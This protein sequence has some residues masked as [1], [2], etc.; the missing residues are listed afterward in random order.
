[1]IKRE[2]KELFHNKWMMVILI[3]VI[4]I[5]TIYT[6]LFLGSMWDP[7]GNLDKLPVAV[8]NEDRSVSYEGKTLSVGKDLQE[9][10]ETDDS[11]D[12][13]IV[14]KKQAK[15]GLK[16]G[17]YYMAIT[18]PEQFSA[19]ATTV[20]DETPKKMTLEY[21][22]NPGT[23][24]IASKL[25][26]SAMEKLKEEVTKE[27][28]K[29]YTEVMFEQI[30]KAG[31]GMQEAATGAGAL[32]DGVTRVLDGNETIAKN[33]QVL[34]ESTLTFQNGSKQLEKGLKTYTDGVVQVKDGAEKLTT[35]I[36]QLEAQTEAAG[37]AL[38]SGAQTVADGVQDYTAVVD[39][40]Y[41]QA[42]A[43][44]CLPAGSGALR[45][46]LETMSDQMTLTDGQQQQIEQ[47]SQ[48]LTVIKEQ[49]DSLNQMMQKTDPNTADA[50]SFVALQQQLQAL[51]SQ[52]DVVLSGSKDTISLL[53]S[54]MQKTKSALDTQL[55][56]GA[57]TL[58]SGISQS[59]QA[60]EGLR[61]ASGTLRTGAGAVKD[62]TAQLALGMKDGISKLEEGSKALLQ[63]SG[64]LTDNSEA[65]L[66]GSSQLTQGAE[67]IGEG[68]A[69]LAD[70]SV[71]EGEGLVQVQDGSKELQSALQDGADTVKDQHASKDTIEMIAAPVTAQEEIVSQVP[72]N[73]HAMA[74]YM[75]SVALW[76]GCIAFSLMYP[77]TKYSGT[78]KSGFTWWM[79]KATVLYTEAVLQAAV[80][81]VLLHAWNG[82]SPKAMG[83]T[84][85]IA[86][87]TSV[88]FMSVMYFFTNTFG[89]I[90]SFLMLIF[91][92]IQLAGSVGTYPLELSGSFVP[93]LH[94]W[95]PFTYSVQ[96][97][98]KS[99]C[100]SGDVK[101]EVCFLGGMLLVFTL[102]TIAEF[103]VRTR[104][105]KENKPL[106]MQYLEEKG[107]A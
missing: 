104:K 34:S 15:E 83:K 4:A 85:A 40:L 56:P 19:N 102:L 16:S 105:V 79:S 26:E 68:A 59:A 11:L 42:F 74:P 28:T 7:Y 93:Y 101:T 67:K 9:K 14:D 78:L 33:L 87:L 18:I 103:A 50:A 80:M 62:G 73:G 70:G 46:G 38:L 20:M 98:R 88:A 86:I 12:F 10:L 96:A 41:N 29:T 63:G 23:N 55:I 77:L 37:N 57:K 43:S 13:H 72:N 100:G 64:E 32:T 6:T 2:W 107:L 48:G 91:M 5:P 94:N 76:V 66:T 84:I 39:Q 75:M 61:N 89:K 31:E 58:E 1:M 71:A 35:G 65:L 95:V 106:L 22:V 47:L 24:Y 49:L 60:I 99:I 90:G 3:A 53:S 25:S 51:T 36:G 92:V 17:T 52:A 97:F 8:V 45:A 30:A 21:Q 44:D 82:F 81:I 27:V 54:G 69:L